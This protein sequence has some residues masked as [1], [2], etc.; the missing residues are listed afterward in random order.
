MGH[1]L[2]GKYDMAHGASLA[3]ILPNYIRYVMQH[4]L[5]RFVQ[6]AQRIFDVDLSYDQPEE[7]VLEM[8]RRLE[9]FSTDLGV[10][11][12]LRDYDIDDSGFAEMAEKALDNRKHVGT[13][14]GIA[15]L[16]KEDVIEVY[17]MSL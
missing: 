5:P 3:V 15:L 17:K 1:E 11:V 6:C 16:G 13:G 14:W 10:P 2:S 9:R 8:V 12:R 4:N 7:T